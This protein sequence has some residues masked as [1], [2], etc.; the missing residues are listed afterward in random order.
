MRPP[1]CLGVVHQPMKVWSGLLAIVAPHSLGA[2]VRSRAPIV[3]AS[4]AANAPAVAIYKFPHVG[5]K[6]LLLVSCQ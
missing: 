2:R 1:S 4:V 6:C 3:M 5:H